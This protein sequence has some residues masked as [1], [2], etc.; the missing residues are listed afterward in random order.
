MG[1]YQKR[2]GVALESDRFETREQVFNLWPEELRGRTQGVPVLAQLA[3]VLIDRNL[4]FV[5]MSQLASA[6][7]IPDCLCSLDLHTKG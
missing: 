3:L 2:T 5:S 4:F 1:I 7:Q 6:E